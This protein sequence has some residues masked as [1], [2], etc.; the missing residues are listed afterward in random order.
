MLN[1]SKIIRS[2]SSHKV[3]TRP[4]KKNLHRTKLT[5]LKR[6]MIEIPGLGIHIERKARHRK[7][8]FS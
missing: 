5:I 6:L 1:V 4:V 2:N 8:V 7:E 3:T